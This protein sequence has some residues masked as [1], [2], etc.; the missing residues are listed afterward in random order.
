MLKKS[1]LIIEIYLHTY[2]EAIYCQDCNVKYPFWQPWGIMNG[3][4]S[5]KASST[6]SSKTPSPKNKSSSSKKQ[7]SLS[8]TPYPHYIAMTIPDSYYLPFLERYQAINGS[9]NYH[10]R[11]GCFIPLS[12]YVPDS[13]VTTNNGIH[14]VQDLD[15]LISIS[16]GLTAYE[17]QRASVVHFMWHYH[18]AVYEFWRNPIHGGRDY[19]Q[20]RIS[21][22]YF[23]RWVKSPELLAT[24]RQKQKDKIKKKELED[25]EKREKKER[26]K[27]LKKRKR[28]QQKSGRKKL[29]KEEE[30]QPKT[31][32]SQT[33]KITAL[34]LPKIRN[35]YDGGSNLQSSGNLLS[36]ILPRTIRF[37]DS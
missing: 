33:I 19:P 12:G 15:K 14:C 7:Q 24:W 3:A 36:P 25:Q 1:T 9:K 2:L 35:L 23:T 17:K 30:E 21:N 37:H 8:K 13:L 32:K 29:N 4:P 20:N 34:N 28:Q 31:P 10:L 5:S 22:T 27:A 6:S 26:E 16:S 11:Y 18:A